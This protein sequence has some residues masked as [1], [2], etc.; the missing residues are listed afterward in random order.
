MKPSWK[1]WLIAYVLIVAGGFLFHFLYDLS[2]NLIFAVLSPVQESVWEHLKILFWPMLIV[3]WGMTRKQE[4]LK[5]SWYLAV[6]LGCGLLLLFGWVVHIRIGL[7]EVLVDVV[8]LMVIDLIA[9]L[10]AAWLNVG[11]RWKGLLL[12]GLVAVTALIVAFTFWQPAGMLFA[13]LSRAETLST[14]PC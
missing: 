14:L 10:A 13:D 2:P 9:L 4:A 5:P 8:G 6:L 7:E 11:E 1:R 12:L 3:G